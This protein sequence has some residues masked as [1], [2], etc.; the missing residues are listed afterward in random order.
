MC[1]E[2]RE[3]YRVPFSIMPHFISLRHRVS[4][5]PGA[6][7]LVGEPPWSSYVFAH[8]S[9]LTGI[10]S[11]AWVRTQVFIIEQQ[12]FLLLSHFLSLILFNFFLLIFF[13]SFFGV[14]CSLFPSKIM[15]LIH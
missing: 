1:A 5:E 6:M 3:G 12:M 11:Y 7:L 2:T 14:Y 9:R 4:T 13:I 8:T 10:S 15:K